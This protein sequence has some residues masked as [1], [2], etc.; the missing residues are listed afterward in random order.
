MTRGTDDQVAP[1][2]SQVTRMLHL[3]I[4]TGKIEPGTPLRERV[5]CEELGVSRT[6]VREALRALESE[7]LVTSIPHRGVVVTTMDQRE[8]EDMYATRSALEALLMRQFTERANQKQL[9]RLGEVVGE[10]TG[11]PHRH[12]LVSFAE[13]KRG[14]YEIISEGAG[15]ASATAALR[16]IY[17]RVAQLWFS[18]FNKQS[19]L[20]QCA[21]EVAAIY[22]AIARRDA[23]A[24]ERACALHHESLSA[25]AKEVLKAREAS[26][27]AKPD[28][29]G[30]SLAAALARIVSQAEH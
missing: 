18:D 19:D 7:G 22:A 28:K 13:G 21:H 27:R 8:V 5:L 11:E 9:E 10:L 23:D 2:R 30:G 17:A 29:G 4:T 25:H 14:F 24:A 20:I 16:P 1:R 3:A 15:N 12:D 6:S 26:A